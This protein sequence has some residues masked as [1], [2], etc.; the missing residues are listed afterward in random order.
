MRLSDQDGEFLRPRLQ[1]LVNR[2]PLETPTLLAPEL[3]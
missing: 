2:R 3:A 1:V